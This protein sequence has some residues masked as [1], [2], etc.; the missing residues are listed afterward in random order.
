MKSW[1]CFHKTRGYTLVEVL[2]VI[3]IVGLLTSLLLV[4][5]Q[6]SREAASR[7]Q[8]KSRLRQIGVGLHHLHDTFGRFPLS[9]SGQAEMV[10]TLYT[11]L[12]P[13]IEQETQSPA[14][15]QPI[16]IL[17][18][19]SRRSASVGPKVDFAASAHPD[20]ISPGGP[21]T[22]WRSIAGP[23]IW[24]PVP[25]TGE[26][27][28][29]YPGATLGSISGQDGTSSTLLLSHKGLRPSWYEAAG[30]RSQ[31]GSWSY[32]Y[33]QHL[34]S[35]AAI[36]RDSE[37]ATVV[38]PPNYWNGNAGKHHIDAFFGSPHAIA[39]PSLY[40]DASVRSLAYNIEQALLVKLWAWN[41][42]LPLPQTD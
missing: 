27:V 7:L 41:D 20:R 19:S 14:E 34:R 30:Y 3:G 38:I 21:L 24:S 32:E 6:T 26:L 37:E 11:Q 15:P 17:L 33:G 2:V 23:P 8:C 40:G 4:G 22:G 13:F 31:D 12:L 39:M 1:Q 18:C 25:G 29:S 16:S 35:W 5:V 42:G 36:A 28:N 9:D 10:P